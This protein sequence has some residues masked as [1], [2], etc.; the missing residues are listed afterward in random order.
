MP[1]AGTLVLGI[2]QCPEQF[3]FLP[4][5]PGAEGSVCLTFNTGP[6]P[7]REKASSSVI[8]LALLEIKC[9]GVKECPVNSGERNTMAAMQMCSRESLLP[10]PY[11]GPKLEANEISP[12]RRSKHPC[13]DANAGLCSSSGRGITLRALCAHLAGDVDSKL[14]L[15]T[16]VQVTW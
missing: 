1:A 6:H 5:S 16:C 12:G 15:H 2:P 13:R 14:S 10:A 3:H 11:P 4:H 9:T 8:P 7:E